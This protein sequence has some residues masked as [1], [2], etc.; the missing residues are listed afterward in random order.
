MRLGKAAATGNVMLGKKGW[1]R[2]WVYVGLALVGGLLL[3]QKP[4]EPPLDAK[5]EESGFRGRVVVLEIRGDDVKRDTRLRELRQVL[6]RVDREGASAVVLRLNTPFGYSAEQA[7]LLL[8]DLAGMRSPVYAYGD[9]AALGMGALL[10]LVAE[11]IYLSPGSV[12][13]GATPDPAGDKDRQASGQALSVLKAQVRSLAAAQGRS[14]RLAEAMIDPEA[15][16]RLQPGQ[17]PEESEKSGEVLTLTAEEAAGSFLGEPPLARGVVTGVEDLVREAKLTGPVLHLARSEWEAQSKRATADA[18]KAQDETM[19]SVEPAG[20]RKTPQ[21]QAESYAGKILILEVGEDDLL[22]QARFEFMERVLDRAR[23][24]KASALILDMN[25]P[26]G[27]AWHTSQL[28]MKPFQNLPFPTYSFVNPHAESAGALLAIATDHIYMY[29]TSTIG[30][31]LVVLSTGADLPENMRQKVEAML[32]SE[33]RN[34]AIAK[35]H[36]P[37]VAEAFVTTETEVVLDGV[38]IS[39]KGE[40]L[41]LNAVEATRVFDGKPLLAKGIAESIDEII[42]KEGLQGEKLE[43]HPR[44]LEAFAEWIQLASVLL[45]AIGLAGAY[46]EL[47]SPGFGVAG[48]VSIA[49]FSL[50]FFGNY[51]AGNLVG[52]GTAVVFALGLLLLVLEFLII[53]GTFFAGAVGALL[54]LGALGVALVDRVEFESFRRGGESAPSIVAVFQTPVVTLALALLATI[55]LMALL[56]RFFPRVGPFGTLVLQGALPGGTSIRGGVPGSAEATE[57]GGR[58]LLG[59]DGVAVTDLRPAGK[60]QIGGGLYDVTT[61]SEW[62]GRG[63]AIRVVRVKGNMILV[64]KAEAV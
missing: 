26:G 24:E 23:N 12:L 6:Q 31:A 58:S 54:M 59:A 53:P 28:I 1:N 11:E 64:G 61:E 44:G 3:S 33:I 30:S 21:G 16:R 49:A 52:Y 20:K 40:V 32:R 19:D 7:G 35:G 13:G 56:M 9:P 46:L 50:F 42:R 51:L 43:V 62:V 18:A 41:N 57:A 55:I 17:K 37:D 34:V 4:Q 5:S 36:N 27:V 8:T 22:S 38:V 39:R 2:L 63:S 60:A 14:A 45:I 47:N 15:A 25:T 29:P 10:A 48:I